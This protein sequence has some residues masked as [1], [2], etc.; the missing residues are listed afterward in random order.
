MKHFFV[1]QEV[2]CKCKHIQNTAK[3]ICNLF[4]WGYFSE[5]SSYTDEMAWRFIMY[6][7]A[8]MK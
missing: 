2:G 7:L 5:Y 4:V 1:K 8:Y 3:L 6:P